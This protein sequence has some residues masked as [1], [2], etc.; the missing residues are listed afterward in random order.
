MCLM[1]IPAQNSFSSLCLPHQPLQPYPTVNC[2]L[3]TQPKLLNFAKGNAPL[4]LNN[5]LYDNCVM[6]L[7]SYESLLCL[8]II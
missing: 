4:F 1:H 3:H 7:L 2:N 6:S 5:E 8:C